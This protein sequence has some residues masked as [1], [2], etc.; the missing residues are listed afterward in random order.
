MQLARH[1]VTKSIAAFI[2]AGEISAEGVVFGSSSLTEK[3][4]RKTAATLRIWPLDLLQTPVRKS[5]R[6]TALLAAV[7]FRQTLVGNL[8][9]KLE[10]STL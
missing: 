10:G 9:S 6:P 7:G 8:L 1:S 5:S 3:S 2:A 4:W